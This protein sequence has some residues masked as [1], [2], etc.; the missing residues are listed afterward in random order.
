MVD[1]A[2]LQQSAKRVLKLRFELGLFD[3]PEDSPF[4]QFGA[5]DLASPEHLELARQSVI[6]GM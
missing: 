3:P 4:A 1:L 6:Q 2:V 5:A